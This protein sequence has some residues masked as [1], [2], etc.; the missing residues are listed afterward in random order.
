[1]H[2]SSTSSPL[3]LAHTC[4]AASRVSFFQVFPWMAT[5]FMR[6]SCPKSCNRCYRPLPTRLTTRF[7]FIS[8]ISVGSV[9]LLA[10]SFT[11]HDV[12]SLLAWT[13]ILPQLFCALLVFHPPAQRVMT[14]FVSSKPRTF[15]T[16][17]MYFGFVSTEYSRAVRS[18]TLHKK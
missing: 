6:I 17:R 14:G 15:I 1:M 4:I 12:C 7:K 13:T 2:D 18:S 3:R 16:L 11:L 8:S 9:I 5:W 10:V